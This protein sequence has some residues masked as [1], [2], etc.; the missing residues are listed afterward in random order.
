VDRDRHRSSED[1]AVRRDLPLSH[2]DPVTRSAADRFNPD[3]Q[4]VV[5]HS[6]DRRE[7]GRRKGGQDHD[8]RHPHH[9]LS[10]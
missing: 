5:D 9:R 2:D 3:E 10:S 6:L 4:A 8:D 1:A 7:A